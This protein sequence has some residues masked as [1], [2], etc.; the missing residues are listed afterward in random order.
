MTKKYLHRSVLDIAAEAPCP[1]RMSDGENCG[2]AL[3]FKLTD[4]NTL[5]C[6]FCSTAFRVAVETSSLGRSKSAVL[7]V[8][9]EE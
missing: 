7:I 5:K 4:E 9:K 8:L 2:A 3:E 1:H 6:T